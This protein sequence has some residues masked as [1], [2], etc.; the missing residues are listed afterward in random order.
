VSPNTELEACNILT[1]SWRVVE[2]YN[3]TTLHWQKK[4]VNIFRIFRRK[5]QGY[6]LTDFNSSVERIS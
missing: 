6:F 2:M 3:A 5:K 4:Y 1:I